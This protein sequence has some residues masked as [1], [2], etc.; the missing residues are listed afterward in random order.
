MNY[1]TL[2]EHW[3]WLLLT[4][5]ALLWYSTVTVYVAVRGMRDIRT[6]FRRLDESA[7]AETEHTIGRCTG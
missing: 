1:Q 7:R 6:M 2:F 3:F 4:I 5:T